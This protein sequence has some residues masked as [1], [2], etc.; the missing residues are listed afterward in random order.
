[1]GWI[2]RHLVAISLSILFM[3]TLA[4]TITYQNTK[5]LVINTYTS[6]RSSIFNYSNG[7]EIGRV[8]REDRLD[9]P[10]IQVPV[11]FRE[12]LLAAED[13]HFYSHFGFDVIAISRAVLKNATTESIQG[14]STITQQYA[15]IAYL[16]PERTISRKVTEFFVTLKIERQYS[17]SEILEKYINALY[18]G[19]NAYGLEVAAIK[20]FG[21]HA[22]ALTPGQAIVLA[23][24]VR[25]PAT[26]D[27]AFK[28]EN[29]QRVL[30]R[31]NGIKKK[32]LY[33]G[34]ITEAE[35]KSITFPEF[36]KNLFENINLGNR[37]HLIAEIKRE[38]SGLGFNDDD[39]SIGGYIVRTTLEQNAQS[40]LEFAV[41]TQKPTDYPK[42]LHI[43]VISIRPKTGEIVALYGGNNY[44]ERQLNDATQSIAQAGS[45]FKVFALIAALEKGYSLSTVWD[46]RSPQTFFTPSG[47]YEVSNYGNSNFGPVSLYRATA[48]S[49]N[50]VFVKLGTKIGA[51]SVVDAARRAGI[52]N[53]VQIL[54]TPSVV[55]GVSSPRVIDIASAFAT[56]AANGIYAK[57]FLVEKILNRDGKV[58]YEAKRQTKRVFSEKVMADLTY[59]LTGVVRNGTASP[60]LAGFPRPI[61]GKTGTSQNNASAW[62]SGYSPDLSTSVAFFGD[63]PER[64]LTGI[65][66][67]N[68]ITGGTFPARIWNAYMR[69][70]L[71]E[72]PLSYFPRPAFVG[73]TKTIYIDVAEPTPTPSVTIPEPIPTY[74]T[75]RQIPIASS[76][77]VPVPTNKPVPVPTNKPVPVPTNKPVPVPTNKPVPNQS[78]RPIPEFTPKPIP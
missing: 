48:S 17:K 4:L 62:F 12:A 28:P 41:E 27:P 67:L 73:G 40:Y 78:A 20:Y 32:L 58:I 51:E 21:V 77:P 15:K 11:M 2:K 71:A 35:F 57:P 25:S 9:I 63:T 74:F 14:G 75:P 34:W 26:Y 64:Q 76:K 72:Y 10:L 29:F 38:L 31:F 33:E 7:A 30:N 22:E 53:V 5:L 54:P 3:C 8:Y 61:A 18:F 47:K 39:L 45:T 46:G 52:P 60:V 69:R 43:G 70:A 42:D 1:M 59:A 19:R 23:A 36:E 56:F 50:T 37:G 24:I 44:L 68:S 55:L 65:G 66:G 6:S 16:K 13:T 49:I